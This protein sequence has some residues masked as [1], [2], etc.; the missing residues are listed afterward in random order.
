MQTKQVTD[1][2]FCES[3]FFSKM[4]RWW[5][6][7]SH[8]ACRS[9]DLKIA[10][11]L[12]DPCPGTLLMSV[13]VDNRM[14]DNFSKGVSVNLVHNSEIHDGLRKRFMFYLAD[15]YF[16]IFTSNKNRTSIFHYRLSKRHWVTPSLMEISFSFGWSSFCF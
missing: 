8:A 11:C 15:V 10:Y 7:Q 2:K 6:F 16:A 12:I 3:L 4:Y 1:L 5:K 9:W 13:T 14:V